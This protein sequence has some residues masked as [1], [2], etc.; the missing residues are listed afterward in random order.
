[1]VLYIFLPQLLIHINVLVNKF[2]WTN[3]LFFIF[4][5]RRSQRKQ[6]LAD[7]RC[8]GIIRAALDRS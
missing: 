4:L 3:I 6:E 2:I 1:M 5:C 8:R 7:R